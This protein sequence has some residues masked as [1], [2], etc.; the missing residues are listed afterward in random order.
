MRLCC[1]GCVLEHVIAGIESICIRK[2]VRGQTWLF[3]VVI[4]GPKANV[5]LVL[6]I[7]FALHPFTIN[8]KISAKSQPS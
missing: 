8:L 6:K 4:I 2:V 7:H 5:D 1:Q 3:S